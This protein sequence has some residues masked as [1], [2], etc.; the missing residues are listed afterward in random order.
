MAKHRYS[1][2][3]Y[4]TTQCVVTF[5]LVL[6]T[7]A[8]LAAN[9]SGGLLRAHLQR[10]LV[11]PDASVLIASRSPYRHQE[12]ELMPTLLNFCHDALK[13]TM[14]MTQ[15][16]LQLRTLTCNSRNSQQVVVSRANAI[17]QFQNELYGFWLASFPAFLARD[18][19]NAASQL[20]PRLRYLFEQVGLTGTTSCVTTES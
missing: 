12:T 14:R 15:L 5:A 7:H 17:G 2:A 6:D 16:A 8:N 4:E 18:D 3:P 11:Q 20:A 13:L 10:E 1:Q 9:T 19:P